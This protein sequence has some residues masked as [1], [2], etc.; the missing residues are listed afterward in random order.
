MT[1]LL[2]LRRSLPRFRRDVNLLLI[3]I[4]LL[5]ISFFGFQMFLKTF[6]ILRLGYG[7]VYLGRFNSASAVSYMALSLPGGAL[8][9]RLGVTRTM[10]IG[11][12]M[13]IVGTA[14]L[15]LSESVP[16][17]ARYYWPILSTMVV[18]GGYALFSINLVPALMGLTSDENRNSAY[19]M[20]SVMRSLGTFVGTPLAGLLP[21]VIVG[22]IGGNLDSPA[23]Y[24]LA[25][26]V[27]P[28]IGLL[29]LIPL[30]RIAE[31]EQID[32]E[33][34]QDHA[35]GILSHRP[36]WPA[37]PF[38]LLQP[39][40]ERHLPLI[41]YGLYGRGVA[42][43]DQHD[44]LDNQ[45]RAA[46]FRLRADAI[47]DA[48]PPPR[49]WLDVDGNQHGRRGQHGAARSHPPMVCRRDRAVRHDGPFGG[50]YACSAGL[51]DG[52]DRT[53]L[54]S[55]GLWGGLHGDG[56]QLRGHQLQRRPDHRQM[57]IHEPV[58]AGGG[59]LVG[60]RDDHVGD[61]EAAGAEGGGAIARVESR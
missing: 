35:T 3:T 41:L 2:S 50:A 40:G 19:A 48:G 32:P 20:S 31:A 16:S 12:V 25:L 33:G 21:G 61:V 4:G 58:R 45:F 17:F 27:G 22:V 15:P 30:L 57:G 11:L 8:G 54:A 24:R 39:G 13:T 1:N 10:R 37:D 51:P 44:R 38:R 5:A 47:A 60:G 53:A 36:C 7:L 55:A 56:P 28:A 52:D 42:S 34:R 18:S 46:C 23:P 14:M 29:A 9:N 49:Q 26:W 59:P 6:Y 43:F